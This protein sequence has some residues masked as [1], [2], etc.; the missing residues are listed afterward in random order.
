MKNPLKRIPDYFRGL[1]EK[2]FSVN[3]AIVEMK[4][5]I[6][7]FNEIKKS[8]EN[9]DES[10][11]FRYSRRSYS[12]DGEDIVLAAFYESLP[13]YKGFYVD[14][15]AF[16]PYRYSNTQ[17]YYERGWSGI[18]IDALPGSM[19]LFNRK[20]VHDINIEAGISEVGGVLQYYSFRE[21]ALNSFN[22]EISELRIREG[23][24]LL[25]K[26]S[27]RTLNINELLKQYVPE[28]KKIDFMNLDVEGLDYVILQ[29]LDWDLYRPDFLLVEALDIV[30]RDIMEY[31]ETEEYNFLRER[32]YSVLARTRRTLI[33]GRG[34]L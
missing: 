5:A 31:E 19:E 20:R 8:V 30:D 23:W 26:E 28:G 17:Y 2:L 34:Q 32:G 11:R 16:H 14:I 1:E 12:Q 29:S 4:E 10:E 24:E 22:Q 21:P 33:F 7:D 27:I 18:N 15:G 25:G 6:A 13:G 3:D 9:L